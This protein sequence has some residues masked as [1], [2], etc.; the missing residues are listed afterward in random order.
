MVGSPPEN[1]TDICRRG[2]MCMALSRISLNVVPGKLVHK[3]HLV[4]VHEA[5]IAHHVAAVGQVHG[6]HGAA[7][8]FDGTGTVVVKTFVVVGANV[9]A[10][11]VLLDPLQ[12]IRVHGHHVFNSGR[13]SGNP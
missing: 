9:A 10:R 5:G 11:E 7:P 3:A 8:V 1:C 6:E 2:L 4:G 13:G 12:E